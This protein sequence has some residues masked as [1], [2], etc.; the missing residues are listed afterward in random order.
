MANKFDTKLIGGRLKSVRR[1]FDFTLDEISKHTGLSKSGIS[2]IEKGVKKPS[3][4][5]MFSLA[6]KFNININWVLTGR[7]R[8]FLPDISFYLDYGID[9]EHVLDMLQA[10]LKSR[11]VRYDFL[12]YFDRIK[13]E[14]PGL[15]NDLF[16]PDPGKKEKS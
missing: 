12:K 6:E 13:K 11:L 8:M 1:H 2:E 5:Y 3:S 4:V 16:G 9:N 15:L 7:G 14:Q 10:I